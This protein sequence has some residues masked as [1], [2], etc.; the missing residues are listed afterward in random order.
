MRLRET[1]NLLYRLITAVSGVR[2]GLAEERAFGGLDTIVR[3]DARLGAI[4]RLDIYANMYFYRL[5]DVLRQDF[6]ATAAVLGEPGF[7]NLVT[8]Y[9]LA[10]PPREP[11]ISHVGRSLAGYLT[12]HPILNQYPFLAELAA[13][14]RALV[15]VF[16]AA[17][18]APLAADSMNSIP[19]ERWGA[20]RLRLSPAVQILK[21]NFK[22]TELRSAVTGSLAW[23]PPARELSQVLVFRRDSEVHYREIDSLEQPAFTALQRGARFAKLCELITPD[24]AP[25]E[26]VAEINRLL[27]CWLNDQLLIAA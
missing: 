21:F 27:T 5:L 4:E 6:P 13:L 17:D 7:H 8:G 16:I 1:E 18:V 12:D 24:A 25:A 2:E 11:S 15:E 20:L 22:V 14:E 26:R 10:Y 23:Q 19:P 3:G 9:L